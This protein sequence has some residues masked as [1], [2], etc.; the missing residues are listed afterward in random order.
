MNRRKMIIGTGAAALGLG[1]GS[2]PTGWAAPADGRKQRLL[3]FT[4]SSGFEHSVIKRQGDQ[5]SYAGK[6]LADLGGK[7]GF[8]ITETKDGG[9]FTPDNLAKYDAVF[10]YTTGDLTQ[11]GTDK[12]PP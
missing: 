5:P 12:N 7:H 9:V 3:F 6:I 10:F 8:E 4:K 2:F 1:L 11:A